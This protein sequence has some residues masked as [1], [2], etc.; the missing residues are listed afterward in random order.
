MQ[1]Y[2]AEEALK[3]AM[4]DGL[5]IDPT[6]KEDNIKK[7]LENDWYVKKMK[8]DFCDW[9]E[10]DTLIPKHKAYDWHLVNDKWDEMFLCVDCF[11]KIVRTVLNKKNWKKT[12]KKV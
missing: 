11:M 10:V 6:P 4:A 7:G 8:C 5:T 12:D 1:N 2:S 3:K 9:R